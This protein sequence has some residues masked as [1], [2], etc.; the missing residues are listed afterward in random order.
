MT[1]NAYNISADINMNDQKLGEVTSFKSLVAILGK[2][3]TRSAEI[4][5][6]IAP[7]MAAMARLNRIWRSNTVSFASKFKLYNYK[8]LVTLS[9]IHI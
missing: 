1:N 2:G 3:G 4:R 7:V 8:S 5:T 9:L 6:R